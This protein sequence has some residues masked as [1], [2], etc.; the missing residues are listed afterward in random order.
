LEE[1]ALEELLSERLDKENIYLDE[2]IDM[3]YEGQSYEIIV[4]FNKDYLE[5]FIENT[6]GPMDMQI[7][8]KM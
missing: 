4:P 6:S 1:R 7:E 5:N 8:T 2:Y 3:R